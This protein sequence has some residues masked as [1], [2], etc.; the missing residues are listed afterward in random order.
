[1]LTAILAVAMRDIYFY[2][3]ASLGAGIFTASLITLTLRLRYVTVKRSVPK[4]AFVDA[5]I[6]VRLTIKNS[7]LFETGPFKFTDFLSVSNTEEIKNSAFVESLF[8]DPAVF[9]YELVCKKRGVY[10]TAPIVFEAFDLFGLFK[11]ISRLHAQSELIVYPCFFDIKYLPIKKGVPSF[12]GEASRRSGDYEEFYGIR[13]YRIDDGLRKIHWPS[14]A[15]FGELMVK[16]YEQSATHKVTVVLDLE[17]GE[18]PEWNYGD[19]FEFMVKTAVSIVKYVTDLKS[20]VQFFAE[21]SESYAAFMKNGQQQ[22]IEILDLLARA[23]FGGATRLETVLDVYDKFIPAG[24]CAVLI[25]SKINPGI[26]ERLIKLAMRKINVIPIIVEGAYRKENSDSIDSIKRLCS[27][28]YII[29]EKD[30]K[31]IET[32]FM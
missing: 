26:F 32:M 28:S 17:G 2:I 14:S 20:S 24:S 16:Q 31:T 1:M 7:S 5:N 18:K 4:A 22:F 27:N 23:Q 13:E 8:K 19:P 12:V 15:R 30:V 6:P 11:K 9:D 3:M 10:E 29:K 25:F 21:G